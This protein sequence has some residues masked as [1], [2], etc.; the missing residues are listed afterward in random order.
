MSQN[1]TILQVMG[2]VVD[3][4]F[5]AGAL[6]PIYA[7]LKVSNQFISDQ[8]N[9]LVLEVAKHLGENTVRAIAMDTTDGLRRGQP[10]LNTNTPIKIPV[11]RKT[12]GRIINVIGEPVDDLGPIFSATDKAETSPIHR[13][14]PEFVDPEAS[15]I[16]YAPFLPHSGCIDPMRLTGVD[17]VSDVVRELM[18]HGNVC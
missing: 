9:N 16:R 18:L 10:V 2:P 6:P 11:G 1:G 7:A 8:E 12:L 3:V 13:A 4:E 5:P 15:D 17:V 14:P